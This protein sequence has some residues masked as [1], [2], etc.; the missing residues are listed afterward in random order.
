MLLPRTSVSGLFYAADIS[1]TVLEEEGFRKLCHFGSLAGTSLAAI[2]SGRF[3]SV[4]DPLLR[5]GK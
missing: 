5:F 1:R 2:H 4:D 3:F